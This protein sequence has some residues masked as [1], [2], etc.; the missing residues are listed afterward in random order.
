M[1]RSRD[2][3]QRVTNIELFFDLVYVFAVT[4]LSHGLLN[5]LT[6]EGALQTALLLGMVW[7][8][9]AYTTW[10]TNWLDPDRTPTRLMLIALML[11]GLVMSTGLPEAFGDRGLAVGGAYAAMQIGRSAYTVIALRGE[12]LQRN[13]ERILAW[14]VVSGALAVAGGFADERWREVLWLSAMLVD[15]IGG[16]VGFYTPGLGRSVTQDWTIEGG[17][18]AERCQAFMLIAL[19]ESIV[20]T[21][22][23]FADHSDGAAT[24][25]AFVVAFAGAVSLWWIYFDRSAADAARIIAESDDPGRL[26]RSAYTLVHPVM[27]AGIIVIA[28]GDEE[29]LMHPTEVAD[30][31]VRW[32]ILGGTALF[33]TGHAL[34]KA[35]V[36]RVVPWTR[37]AV[38]VVLALMGLLAPHVYAV[39][40]AGCVVLL[41]VALAV[42]DRIQ[43]RSMFEVRRSDLVPAPDSPTRRQS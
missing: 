16:W 40:L 41:L 2:G 22:A 9:W 21:G 18:F 24:V 34:F 5:H 15:F 10:V 36:W 29:V 3:D 20:V 27:I 1:L 33:V 14:C 11:A 28:A 38:V 43:S 23:T 42:A 12:R 39:T 8:V 30:V 25:A 32:L 17:H 35:I 37:I 13:F 7:L 26:G 6:V 19:G 31:P 4:Q